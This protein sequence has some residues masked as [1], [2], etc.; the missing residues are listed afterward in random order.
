MKICA[1]CGGDPKPL[2]EYY[3]R[4]RSKD[5][6]E[7]GCK[8]CRKASVAV[9]KRKRTGN[10]GKC[11]ICGGEREYGKRYCERCRK[12]KRKLDKQK[13]NQI[14]KIKTDPD[15]TPIATETECDTCILA[16]DC[17]ERVKRGCDPY[18]W[19]G[20]DTNNKYYYLYEAAIG[21]KRERTPDN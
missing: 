14:N 4:K 8:S 19:D 16:I 21:K 17:L 13:N 7:N 3:K 12:G 1:T 20:P 6:H 15:Y 9:A 5:G 2:N 18:C 10:N 11:T